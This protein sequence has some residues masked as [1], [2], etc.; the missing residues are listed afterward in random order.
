VQTS[1]SAKEA[2]PPGDVRRSLLR[3]GIVRW[4]ST[5]TGARHEGD[6]GARP[7]GFDS[8]RG[9]ALGSY[10][11]QMSAAPLRS[12]ARKRGREENAGD[13]RRS[14]LVKVVVFDETAAG[15]GPGTGSMRDS[16]PEQSRRDR[17]RQRRDQDPR[18]RPT[19][20]ERQGALLE[21]TQAKGSSGSSDAGLLGKEPEGH[22]MPAKAGGS[23]SSE[24]PLDHAPRQVSAGR[25]AWKL[26]PPTKA[27]G[28]SD[29]RVE[30]SMGCS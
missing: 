22:L 9:C 6:L 10:G 1:T 11:L 19:T 4:S 12:T 13:G 17:E 20:P 18:F 14:G 16:P 2:M 29:S 7:L 21:E 25:G 26:A 28:E 23:P 27:G 8:I 30:R 5:S 3:Q 24:A 15:V